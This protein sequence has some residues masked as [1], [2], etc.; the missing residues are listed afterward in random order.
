MYSNIGS[1]S[2]YSDATISI[3]QLS[4]DSV[5]PET[6]PRLSNWF[7]SPRD[8]HGEVQQGSKGLQ[9]PTPNTPKPIS[10]S[11][12]TCTCSAPPP[13]QPPNHSQPKQTCT[14]QTTHTAKQA[15]NQTDKQTNRHPHQHLHPPLQ[16]LGDTVSRLRT[17]GSCRVT[18]APRMYLYHHPTVVSF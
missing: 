7:P 1:I 3:I 15:S 16:Y 6:S 10:I 11:N 8:R 14:K 9:R 17:L 5:L 4:K 13:N 18:L 12:C 2:K